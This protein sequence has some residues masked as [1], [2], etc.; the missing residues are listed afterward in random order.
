MKG[1]G[2][3]VGIT[4]PAVRPDDHVPA[5]GPVR[6]CFFAD[7]LP[8]G[9][10]AQKSLQ[11][12]QTGNAQFA[13]GVGGLGLLQDNGASGCGTDGADM[14]QVP[15]QVH[16]FPTQAADLAAAQAQVARQLDHQLQL[17]ALYQGKQNAQLLRG[18]KKLLG[19]SQAGRLH[20]IY[21]IFRQDALTKSGL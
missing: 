17:M 13:D 4:G 11:I 18:I 6:V 1:S 19:T 2:D 12:I 16:V 14:D 7:R 3:P 5:V 10:P 9:L 20:P 21:R 15:L 8:L